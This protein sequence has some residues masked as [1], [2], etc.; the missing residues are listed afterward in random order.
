MGSREYRAGLTRLTGYDGA[1]AHAHHASLKADYQTVMNRFGLNCNAAVLMDW[2]LV[3]D[4]RSITYEHL[5]SFRQWL[6]RNENA[7]PQQFL[8]FIDQQAKQFGYQLGSFDNSGP[9]YN[10]GPKIQN[11]A[12]GSLVQSTGLTATVNG[13]NP[14]DPVLPHVAQP[15][16]IG[17]VGISVG[18]IQGLKD[19]IGDLLETDPVFLMPCLDGKAP[20][21]NQQLQQILRELAVGI[22]QRNQRPIFSLHFNTDGSLYPVSPPDYANTMVGRVMGMLDYHMKAFLNGGA[23]DEAFI[24]E[25]LAKGAGSTQHSAGKM[26]DLRSYIA[27]RVG[28]GT[29]YFSMREL[30][31]RAGIDSDENARKVRSSFRIIADNPIRRAIGGYAIGTDF[32][33][34]Y[35]IDAGPAY[36]EELARHRKE[37]GGDSPEHTALVTVHEAMALLIK[38]VMPKMPMCRDMFNMLG[39]IHFFSYYFESLKERQMV[40]LLPVG[41]TQAITHFPKMLPPLPIRAPRK[42]DYEL[43]VEAFLRHLPGHALPHIEAAVVSPSEVQVAVDAMPLDVCSAIHLVMRQASFEAISLQDLAPGPPPESLVRANA[44]HIVGYLRQVKEKIAHDAESRLAALTGDVQNTKTAYQRQC[45]R[46]KE[47][48]EVSNERHQANRRAIEAEWQRHRRVIYRPEPYYLGLDRER[49]RKMVP[50][51]ERKVARFA[52][53]ET[54]ATLDREHLK[55]KWVSTREMEARHVSQIVQ[56]ATTLSE[57]IKRFKSAPLSSVDLG[58]HRLAY[59]LTLSELAPAQPETSQLST[60][61][62]GGCGMRLQPKV[63]ESSPQVAAVLEAAGIDIAATSSET[64][65][66][67][68]HNGRSYFYFKLKL[69]PYGASSDNDFAWIN[70]LHQKNVIDPPKDAFRAVSLAMQNKSVADLRAALTSNEAEDTS[71]SLWRDAWGMGF[72][73]Y[74]AANMSGDAVTVLIQSGFDLSAADHFGMTPLHVAAVNGNL[75]FAQGL[76]ARSSKLLQAKTIHGA[77]AL[78]LAAE[79]GQDE[80]VD[81]LLAHGLRPNA[82][83]TSGMSTVGIAIFNGHASIA[84]RL[85]K[86]NEQAPA[87][88]EYGDT[89]L[90]LATTMGQHGIIEALLQ[91]GCDVRA[92][93]RDGLTA[94]HLAVNEGDAIAC[95]ILLQRRPRGGVRAP[96]SQD[97]DLKHLLSAAGP[98]GLT[99]LH[100]AAREG[101]A[102]VMELLLAHGADVTQLTSDDRTALDTA[103]QYGNVDCAKHLLGPAKNACDPTTLTKCL[104][105]AMRRGYFDLVGQMASSGFPLGAKDNQG[106]TLAHHLCLHGQ[107]LRLERCLEKGVINPSHL[108]EVDATGRTPFGLAVEYGQSLTI[109]YLRTRHGVTNLGKLPSTVAAYAARHGCLDLLRDTIGSNG[110]D[111][112]GLTKRQGCPNRKK[113]LAYLA[114]ENGKSVTLQFLLSRGAKLQYTCD[115]VHHHLLVASVAGA[116]VACIQMLARVTKDLNLVSD[117]HGRGLAEIAVLV[118]GL[119]VLKCL[120][121]LGIDLDISG[122]AGRA[123]FKTAAKL[124]KK[125][126][127]DWLLDG[128]EGN[129]PSPEHLSL[130]AQVGGATAIAVAC[131]ASV[132][133]NMTDRDGNSP[134]VHAVS[135]GQL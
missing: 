36:E 14:S 104:T 74:A 95:E 13:T 65:T 58:K 92:A 106:R 130:A 79:R 116:N 6:T 32:S 114:A 97:E 40:P 23:F 48:L 69:A 38:E 108:K 67:A 29:Q 86:L 71:I 126:V 52:Q 62:V 4:H 63:I 103:I 44:A 93:R 17:G 124:D 51:D 83:L 57:D 87:L 45:D 129:V 107:Y 117:E 19:T 46:L 120:R 133:P 78:Y 101:H 10:L 96:G 11:N 60:S 70:S 42:M 134:L 18:K 7:T 105:A 59:S 54:A 122:E 3:K 39:A 30:M 20:F 5:I 110:T 35:T 82:V 113:S 22:Y 98:N 128:E 64:W 99:A 109:E 125:D 66:R 100:V 33:V 88:P 75:S 112:E 26:I 55:S 34:E 80:M 84:Q 91:A 47:E 61:I 24:D 81:A 28:A 111:V 49:R 90:H 31:V 115:G 53:E 50:H 37:N 16:Q 118:A 9:T 15:G 94:L 76:V 102:N 21:S 85:I 8:I 12:F 77:D 2:M 131:E 41:D 43:S 56:A 73:H 89:A 135:G 121:R 25:W 132:D 119:E 72:S 123:A 27:E 68:E 127:I 1:E